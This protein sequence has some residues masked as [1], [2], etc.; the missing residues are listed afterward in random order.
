ME[1][2]Q[3]VAKEILTEISMCKHGRN[4]SLLIS[5]ECNRLH[6]VGMILKCNMNFSNEGT[7]LPL[8]ESR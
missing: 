2:L 5:T 3:N 7:E 4:L 6:T 1:D 8:I